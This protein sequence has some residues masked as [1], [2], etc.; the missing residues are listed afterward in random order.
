[1]RFCLQQETNHR[2]AVDLVID[3]QTQLLQKTSCEYVAGGRCDVAVQAVQHHH[4][5]AQNLH[6]RVRLVRYIHELAHFRRV[7]LFVFPA[8]K[9]PKHNL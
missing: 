5:H 9:E 3:R 4:L 1:M 6:L 7:N 2:E 8:K